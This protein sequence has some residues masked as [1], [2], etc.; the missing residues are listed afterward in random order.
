M[1]QE[2]APVRQEPITHAE[3]EAAA[4]RLRACPSVPGIVMADI[5]VTRGRG[6]L[7]AFN[8]HPVTPDVCWHACAREAVDEQRPGSRLA[9]VR[10]G[11]EPGE[12]RRSARAAVV[13]RGAGALLGAGAAGRCCSARV[14]CAGRRSSVPAVG[15]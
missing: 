10:A 5:A 12:R 2:T 1:R 11:V 9:R 13:V 3:A 8:G 7:Q 6:T 15:R 4:L 14:G